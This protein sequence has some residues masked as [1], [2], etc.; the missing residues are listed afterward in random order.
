MMIYQGANWPAD[1]RDLLYTINFHGRRLNREKLV[2]EG[3]G[4]V[5]QHHTDILQTKDIWFRGI[6]VCSGP[7]G[8]V[9][10]LDWSDI[11]ECHDHDGVHRSSGRIFKVVAGT[12]TALPAFDLSKAPAEQLAAYQTH[13]DV[14][15]ARQARQVLQQRAASGGEVSAALA[16]LKKLV[17]GADVVHRLRALWCLFAIGGIDEAELLTLLH[18]DDEHTRVWALRLLTDLLPIHQRAS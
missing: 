5:G 16:P 10:I 8:G 17:A 15:F 14:W 6:E 7:D 3:S 9:Y 13:G 11:G 12:P 18:H 4:F 2:R 1:Y